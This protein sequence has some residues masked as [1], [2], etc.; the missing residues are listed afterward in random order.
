MIPK[1]GIVGLG[2]MGENHARVLSRMDSVQLVGFYDPYPRKDT[3]PNIFF[4]SLED[5]AEE[6]DYLIISS[7]TGSHVENALF[8]AD[9]GITCLIEK[10]LAGSYEDAE[11]IRRAFEASG[12]PAAVGMVERF[13]I[14]AS[15]ARNLIAIG[16]IGEIQ[17]ISTTREGPFTG[18]IQDVGVGLDLASHDLDLIQ[19]ITG[20]TISSI[21]LEKKSLHGGFEDYLVA[22]GKTEKQSSF[23]LSVNWRCPVKNRTVRI[24]G[25]L[26]VMEVNLMEMTIRL[27]KSGNKAV[28]WEEM[29]QRFG[30]VVGDS[31]LIGL[32]KQEPLVLQHAEIREFWISGQSSLL[33]SLTE[34]SFVVRL[35][36]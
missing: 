18:R 16:E 34:A 1:V 32:E 35:L 31:F 24:Y 36:E 26:G 27:D 14:A 28:A 15:T 20:Q 11:K 30:E 12:T 21:S 3:L 29:K 19:W 7:P 4:S 6:I 13:N 10:P 9:H 22:I 23:S 25:E 33:C 5:L 8:A 2:K 17:H